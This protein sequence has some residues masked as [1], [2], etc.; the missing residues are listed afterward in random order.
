MCPIGIGKTTLAHEI[1]LQWAKE[2]FLTKE[3][4]LVILIQLRAVQ[5]RTLQQ[6]MIDAVGSETSYVELLTKCHGNRCLII[7]EGLDEISAR[8]QE[9]DE[10]FS[11]LV[12][13]TTF[14]SCA[15]IIITSRPHACVHL[16]KDK[17]FIRTIEIV[18]FGKT[19]I[20]EYAEMY[21]DCRRDLNTA[22][23]S[24]LNTAEKFMEQVHSDPHISSLC[25]VPLCL[26]MVLECYKHSDKILHKT[27]TEL[28]QSFV[29]S[30][31]NYHI[32]HKK[33]MPLGTVQDSD[34]EYFKNLANV[35]SDVPEFL[36]GALETLFLLS[37]LAYKSY[38]EW[39]EQ[40]NSNERNSKIVYDK[41]HLT[42]CNI[43]NLKND[44][45][46]LLKATNT[47]YGTGNT[48]VYTFNHLSVQEYFCALYI[49]LL[50]EDQQLQLLKDHITDHPH[51]WPFHAGITKLRSF[52]VSHYLQQ[53]MLQDKH[54]ENPVQFEN[55]MFLDCR[56]VARNCNIS[57][58]QTVIVLNSIH[59]A[60]LSSDVYKNKAHALFMFNYRFRQYDYMCISYFMSTAPITQLYLP[61]CNIRDQ[62]VKI[63]IQ[64]KDKIP[65]LKVLDLSCN[66][67]TCKGIEY[68]IPIITNLTHLSVAHN[69]NIGDD[70]IKLFSEPPLKF[71]SLIQLDIR[72][73]GMTIDGVYHGLC[74]Y[75]KHNDLLQ[76][77]EV[78]YNNIAEAG[79]TFILFVMVYQF[80]NF[81][82]SLTRLS[83]KRCNLGFQAVVNVL[84]M[85]LSL[86]K[87]LKY[88]DISEN[89]IEDHGMRFLSLSLKTNETLIQLSAHS[90]GFH[91]FGS[92][93]VADM[94][95]ENKTLKYL[96]I[97]NN[98]IGD[99]GI[100]T[101]TCSIEV[102]TTLIQLKI[103]DGG[104]GCKGLEAVNKMLMVN[105]TLK[106]LCISV[107]VEEQRRIEKVG[108]T[109]LETFLKSDC[110]LPQLNVCSR[111]KGIIE[112]INKAEVEMS[113]TT[114]TDATQLTV[115]ADT[116]RPYGDHGQISRYVLKVAS[117]NALSV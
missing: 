70:G 19:R 115:N 89:H 21:F 31:V 81:T 84:T 5:E 110:K 36:E 79:L 4:D 85:A 41:K 46:G 48:S 8:W 94:L 67:I 12:N 53:Y 43:T 42:H 1:C 63:L 73:I 23:K 44:A 102:N 101:I 13:S 2:K 65:S 27:F 25:Y 29:V 17:N 114:G 75:L 96:N 62:E 14:L 113:R 39:C 83:I 117:Y 10:M 91:G 3:Y 61:Y 22:E 93:C 97:S 112:F 28:Y 57:D 59:E 20:K 95:L 86:Y 54:L 34:K 11:K 100:T 76:S 56:N 109:V 88:L 77:L 87:T 64:C 7:L 60:Q 66:L 9:N 37:K 105:K 111:C 116:I 98:D 68:L 106:E 99:D 49:S 18:G 38:F 72:Y 92:E 90:C 108:C 16:C 50:P 55:P 103:Y 32:E 30:R 24:S 107:R 58:Q 6:V 40:L 35:L 71:S 33:A 26:D 104:Y 74:E 52:D 51:L 69:F 45:C 47:L 78:S 82:T 15:N 80:F